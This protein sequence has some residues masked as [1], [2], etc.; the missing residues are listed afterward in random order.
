MFATCLRHFHDKLSTVLP[1]DADYL[2]SAL[3]AKRIIET[4]I[5]K[6]PRG[7]KVMR[8]IDYR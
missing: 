7:L 4:R 2:L 5:E 1:G 6:D 3:Y 8:C